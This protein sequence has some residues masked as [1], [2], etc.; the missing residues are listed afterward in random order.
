MTLSPSDPATAL[1]AAAHAAWVAGDDAGL[2]ALLERYGPVVQGVCRRQLGPGADADDCAQAVLLTLARAGRR[3][4]EG[5]ALGGWLHRVAVRA[6]AQHLRA[7][8]RRRRHEAAAAAAAARDVPGLDEDGPDAALRPALDAALDVLPSTQRAAIVERFFVGRDF[9]SVGAVLGISADAAKK[10]VAAALVR[11]RVQLARQGLARTEAL[12][13]EILAREGLAGTRQAPH[14]H[15]LLRHPPSA[16]A[17]HLLEALRTMLLLRSLPL[18]ATLVVALALVAAASL[19]AADPASV[20]PPPPAPP[21][22]PAPAPFVKFY[23]LRD[24]IDGQQCWRDPTPPP[25]HPVPPPPAV[26]PGPAAAALAQA[27]TSAAAITVLRV[28]LADADPVARCSIVYSGMPHG[29]LCAA[30]GSAPDPDTLSI[31][32]TCIGSMAEIVPGVIGGSAL[33]VVTTRV[34]H[35]RI[36]AVLQGARALRLQ[37]RR[38]WQDAV[39]AQLDGLRQRLRA[40][41][42]GTTWPTGIVPTTLT[43]SDGGARRLLPVVFL[44]EVPCDAGMV[45]ILIAGAPGSGAFLLLAD[46][47]R[48]WSPDEELLT[49]A[50]HVR[51]AVDAGLVPTPLTSAALRTAGSI[52]LPAAPIP[53]PPHKIL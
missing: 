8:A 36:D 52:D 43:A 17:L 16:A 10:R 15:Q 7:R 11:L 38:P 40:G 28:A 18:P 14:V 30:L 21:P 12:L 3:I 53:A 23:D 29:D 5:Q 9:S 48:I 27:R 2:A 13:A 1:D 46:G 33:A 34:G 19:R 32:R 6:C 26:V 4:R 47:E 20:A 39:A 42:H 44:P 25:A 35:D 37:A 31:A 49:W 41:A 50:A 45:P 51:Q 24:L 22:V